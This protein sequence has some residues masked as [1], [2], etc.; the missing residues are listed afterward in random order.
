MAVDIPIAQEHMTRRHEFEDE[1]VQPFHRD[2]ARDPEHVQARLPIRG[3]RPRASDQPRQGTRARPQVSLRISMHTQRTWPLAAALVLG[4]PLAAAPQAPDPDTDGDGRRRSGSRR[5]S[6]ASC[7]ASRR[8]APMHRRRRAVVLASLPFAAACSTVADR[9]T[10]QCLP[11]PA[12][13]RPIALYPANRPPLQPSPLA[14]L[15]LGAV[16]PAGWLHKQLELQSQGFHGHLAE[17]SDFLQPDDNAWLSPTG[18]GRRGWEEVPYWLKGFFDCAWLLDDAQQIAQARRWIEGALHG[19]RDDGFFGPRPGVQATVSSTQGRYDL[20]PNMVMLACL[21]SYHEATGDPR[22]LELLRRYFRWELTVPEADFLPPYWQHQRGG[23]N[24]WSVYWLFDRTGESWLLELARKIQRHTADWTGGVPDWHNVNMAQA[25]GG[26]AFFWMQSGDERH[27]LASERDWQT[28]RAAYGQVPG[29]MFGGDE[30]CRPGFADPRQ[31]IETCGMVEMMFSCERLL[32]VTGETVWADRCEDVAFNSLPAALLADFKGLRYLTGP[33]QPLSDGRSKAPGVQNG[34]P[35]F[36]FDPRDHRCCQHNCGHGW[37]YFVEHLWMA[38]PD[39]GLAAPLYGPCEVRAQCGDGAEVTITEDTQYPFRD[40]IGLTVA[41]PVAVAF[42]LF[43]RVPG[44]CSAPAL[45]VDGQD[46]PLTARAGSWLR[47]DRTWRAGATRVAL[48]LP[49]AVSLRVW[50]RNQH[51]VSVDRGPLTFSLRIGERLE[52]VRADDRWPAWAIAPTTPWNYALDGAEPAAF[53]VVERPWPQDDMPFTLDG[54]PVELRASGRRVA[55]WQLDPTGLV[56]RLQPSPVRTGSPREPITLV[57]MGAAR[58][59]IAAFPVAGSGP[60]SHAWEPPPLAWSFLPSASCCGKDDSLEALRDGEVPAAAANLR[61][62]PRFTWWD[63]KG[64]SEWVQ[65]DFPAARQVAR[66]AVFWFDD[67]P[68]GGCAVP[69]S[70]RLCYRD[71]ETWQEVAAKGP[72]GT[73]KGGFQEV[74]FAPV[75]TTALRIEVKL[76]DGRSGGLYEWRVE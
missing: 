72:F 60:D 6:S 12:G 56:G 19:Q 34:G 42:P 45:A 75:A 21:Q 51:S 47:L 13:A 44:W 68:G 17:I 48:R 31:C 35:M 59:R 3:D 29:G 18:E 25:L 43:L 46:V 20:W 26:P 37:P 5:R 64:T 53:A 71:G 2:I 40:A 76:Q 55:E 9:T 50:E 58:L 10:V 32:Q 16:R 23:D 15:P 63:H 24:L 36:L 62:F 28:I 8:F 14:K 41:A 52:R 54:A 57:P 70:W 27:R 65:Y 22:V 11:Q 30:N 1:L 38:A 69:A 67:Q 4:S 66:V 7:A 73:Q 49:M 61:D 74:E 39:G 33:N